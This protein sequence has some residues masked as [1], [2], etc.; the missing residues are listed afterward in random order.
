MCFG[1]A[2]GQRDQAGGSAFVSLV[3]AV[4]RRFGENSSIEVSTTAPITGPNSV[5]TP[6]RMDTKAILIDSAV[7][8]TEPGS[9]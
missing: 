4:G 7:D 1:A 8:S 3:R 9:I 2:A 5:P 6:P